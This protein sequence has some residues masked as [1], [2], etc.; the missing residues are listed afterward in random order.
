M[1]S[2]KENEILIDI[3]RK[4]PPLVCSFLLVPN[5]LCRRAVQK[6][7]IC[8]QKILMVIYQGFWFSRKNSFPLPQIRIEGIQ[9]QKC[10]APPP[11]VVTEELELK[12]CLPPIIN[13]IFHSFPLLLASTQ[14]SIELCLEIYLLFLDSLKIVCIHELEIFDILVAC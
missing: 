4:I 1:F 7:G 10:F 5:Q 13:P 6:I 11:L 8:K 3:F 12:N 2:H 14:S 9:S